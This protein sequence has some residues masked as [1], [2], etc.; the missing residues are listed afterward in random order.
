V[1]SH[2]PPC[3]VPVPRPADLRLDARPSSTSRQFL[4]ARARKSDHPPS[5][6]EI[7]IVTTG[8]QRVAVITGASQGIGAALVQ[9]YRKSGWAVVADSHS[10]PASDDPGVVTVAGD[11]A[12][13]TVARGPAASRLPRA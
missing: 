1:A 2:R 4:T 12:D 8:N 10:I 13:P 3:G 7:N 9:A 6:R 5:E 11:I